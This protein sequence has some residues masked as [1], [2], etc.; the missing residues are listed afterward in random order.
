ML[1]DKPSTMLHYDYTVVGVS[2][3]RDVLIGLRGFYILYQLH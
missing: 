1:A 2:S 3:P